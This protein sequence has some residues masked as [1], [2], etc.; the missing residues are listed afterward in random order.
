MNHQQ[1]LRL[2][3]DLAPACETGEATAIMEV[4]NS[5]FHELGS[6]RSV[7]CVNDEK[8][9]RD[10][11]P[12]PRDICGKGYLHC[13]LASQR[14]MNVMNLGEGTDF[15]C[16]YTISLDT[17]FP[18]YLRTRASGRSL[19][20]LEQAFTESLQYLAPHR[21]GIDIMPYLYEN[22]DSVDSDPVWESVKAY[23]EF[24]HAEDVLLQSN[25]EIV[26]GISASDLEKK[27]EGSIQIIQGND[28]QTLAAHAK[29]NW[30]VA[31]SVLLA[32]ATIHIQ[33]RKK[34]ARFRL[35]KLLD[36]L[37]RSIGLFPQ[38]EIFFAHAFFDRGNQERFFR[39]IQTNASDLAAEL[40]NMAWD[41]AHPRTILDNVSGIAR[42][43]SNHADFV[44]PYFFTFDQPVR[45]LLEGFQFN[46]LI[47]YMDEG[48][49][50]IVIFPMEVFRRLSDS[51]RGSEGFFEPDRIQARRRLG[52]DFHSRP[53]R[54]HEVI[55]SAESELQKALTN[56]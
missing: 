29:K 13:F 20:D 55:A 54:R 2:T 51:L 27:V 11:L 30:S 32:A 21:S 33:Y 3:N 34:G 48:A 25:G 38:Q 28:W 42:V 8:Y 45:A 50:H 24:I 12:E 18:S 10:F 46:A 41:L 35:G 53:D 40:R 47:S 44:V 31:Y 16:T 4:M 37:D 1:R 9:Y 26:V 49:K 52:F 15:R 19:N 36:Y 56:N 17:N 23:L 6:A 5:H 22:A 7:F 39:R 43:N 14:I